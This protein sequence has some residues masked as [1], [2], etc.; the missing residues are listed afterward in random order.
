MLM[1]RSKTIPLKAVI[2]CFITLVIL[3]ASFVKKDVE[4]TSFENRTMEYFHWPMVD[5][6]I[7]G[8]WF[9]TFE[10][11]NLDQVI[12]REMLIEANSRGLYRLGR[13]QINGITVCKDD[14]LLSVR[15]DFPKAGPVSSETV[16]QIMIPFRDAAESYGGQFYYMNIYPRNLHYWEVFPYHEDEM[17]R[18]YLDVN[19]KSLNLIRD[20][21]IRAVDTYENMRR[22]SDEYLYFHTDHHYTFRGAYY[23]Y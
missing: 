16:E 14:S 21:G 18:D 10:K 12:G 9:E 15:Y 4:F 23:S 5:T 3:V 11:Y 13:R 2:F 17:I 1:F 19:T 20:N 22:H 7:S 8:E 6:V